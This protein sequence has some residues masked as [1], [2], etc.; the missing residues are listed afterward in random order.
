MCKEL[1]AEDPE[2]AK[3]KDVV[4]KLRSAQSFRN[5]YILVNCVRELFRDK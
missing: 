4:A 1:M 2:L 5:R 3:H